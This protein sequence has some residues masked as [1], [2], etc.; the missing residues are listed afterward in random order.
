MLIC[1]KIVCV[2]KTAKKCFTSGFSEK[3][4]KAI[5]E[6]VNKICGMFV[7]VHMYVCVVCLCKCACVCVFEGKRRIL[8]LVILIL[9]NKGT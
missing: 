6:I 5:I 3:I 9:E 8:K 7:C 2:Q 1:K 4:A